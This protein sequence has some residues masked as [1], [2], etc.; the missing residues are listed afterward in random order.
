[1]IPIQAGENEQARALRIIQKFTIRECKDT[2]RVE[3]RSGDPREL[4]ASRRGFPVRKRAVGDGAQPDPAAVPAEEFPVGF[5]CRFL[6]AAR[7]VRRLGETG[8]RVERKSANPG[9]KMQRPADLEPHLIREG[10][11]VPL[12][13]AC[14]QHR[15]SS[16]TNPSCDPVL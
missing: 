4:H 9:L 2:D 8:L 1:M 15:P 12:C 16:S 7:H 13:H 14:L 5:Q 6:R 11:E 10:A 3:S